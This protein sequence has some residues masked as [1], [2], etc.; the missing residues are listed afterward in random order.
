MVRKISPVE[1]RQS[2]GDV[3]DSVSS[4]REPVIVEEKGRPVAVI[5]NPEDYATLLQEREARAWAA[6]ERVQQANA[7]KD[8]DEILAEVT[9]VVEEVRRERYERQTR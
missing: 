8:P 5:I 2:I 9:E 4:T 1:A 7:D 6:I 3:L